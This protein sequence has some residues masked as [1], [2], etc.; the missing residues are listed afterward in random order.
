MWPA[1]WRHSK[2]RYFV[3]KWLELKKRVASLG[4]ILKRGSCCCSHVT[5]GE[6]LT[7]ML[8]SV[9]SPVW[10]LMLPSDAYT[11]RFVSRFKSCYFETEICGKT[12]WIELRRM[13]RMPWLKLGGET[14]GCSMQTALRRLWGSAEPVLQLRAGVAPGRRGAQRE[15]LGTIRKCARSFRWF[16]CFRC[17]GLCL[18]L[19]L[20]A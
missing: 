16:R 2:L 18:P 9:P 11:Q 19:Q 6:I 1:S 20:G 13:G 5:V 7:V 4:D 3:V 8:M 15:L 10:K 14:S 17:R 12:F